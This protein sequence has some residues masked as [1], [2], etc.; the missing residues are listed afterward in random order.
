MKGSK[1]YERYDRQLRLKEFGETG[2]EKLAAAKVLVIGAGGLGSPALL[3]LAAAGVGH[4]GI[5]DDDR[6]TLDNLHRQVLFATEDT[7]ELKA[8]CA[9]RKLTALNP[10]NKY[11]VYTD[12][13]TN[14]TILALLPEYDII[15]DGSD[16]F[17][18]RYMVNDACLLFDKP[19]IY[20]AVSRFE[21]QVAVFNT[22]ETRINYRDLF[23][24]PP[25]NGE[26]LN[27]AEAGV[28]GTLPGII[29]TLQATEAIK[30]I[31]GIGKPLINRLL[32]YRSLQGDFF[33]V[34]LPSR[35]GSYALIPAD[36][37]SF[38]KTDYEWLCANDIEQDGNE[39]E[40]ALLESLIAR[41]N[42]LLVDVRDRGELPLLRSVSHIHIPLAELRPTAEMKEAETIVLFCQSGLRSRKGASLLR[43]QLSRTKNIFS[44]K[45]GMLAWQKVTTTL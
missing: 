4:I 2:Q 37:A 13:L 24:H 15:I 42:V 10:E 30:L 36:V 40:P 14:A 3:Y 21:G 16:N 44:L 5:V 19:L 11:R 12:R 27:C 25:K 35:P 22:G 39:I 32:T 20:G 18:T 34:T 43:E 31:T 23:P 28:L 1:T 6:V 41:Q 38:E 45:G 26:V 17:P 29:G 7:G 9:A 33:E 8:V